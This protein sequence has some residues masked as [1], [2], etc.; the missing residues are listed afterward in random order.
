LGGEC[1]D[2]AWGTFA[3]KF[4]KQIGFSAVIGL[5]LCGVGMVLVGSVGLRA[6]EPERFSR[7]GAVFR[8][9]E[10]RIVG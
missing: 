5:L 1:P 2:T 6:I 10:V 3:G 8:I 9:G 4:R 7:V